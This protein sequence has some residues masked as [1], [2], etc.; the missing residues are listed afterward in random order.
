MF[1]RCKNPHFWNDGFRGVRQKNRISG[2][3]PSTVAPPLDT[4]V[5]T[6]IAS[7]T[8]FLYTGA[9]PIQTG[10]SPNIIVP[11]RAAKPY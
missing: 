6:T 5:A 2:P 11:T 3:D 7:G 9:N 8:S 1:C 4:S 10:V